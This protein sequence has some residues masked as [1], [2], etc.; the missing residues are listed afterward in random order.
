MSR[1]RVRPVVLL[2]VTLSTLWPGAEGAAPRAHDAGWPRQLERLEERLARLSSDID[3]VVFLRDFTARLMDVGRP[4]AATLSRYRAVDFS[5]FDDA[6]YYPQFRDDQL[7]AACGITTF[8]YLKL[9]QRFGF[10]AYQYSFGFTDPPFARFIHSVTLVEVEHDGQRRLVVQDPYLNLT[11]RT[12]AGAP[13]DFDE[14]LRALQARR[15]DDIVMD[16]APVITSLL[17]PDLAVY[18]AQLS[19]Q[20]R[21]LMR[22]VLTRAD[23]TRRTS[24]P[25]VRSYATLMQ[26]PCDA[27]EAGFVAALRQHGFDE[28]LLFAYTLRAAP[29]VGSAGASAVQQHIDDLLGRRA[30][31]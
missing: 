20:C 25:I 21:S 23:G 4:D 3:K 19:P 24:L 7:P 29:V 6:A 11:Y 2:L 8:F 14:F 26:S 13:M 17:V 22:T 1:G 9:L 30:D 18:D 31:P 28:P 12:R 15:Y 27:F 10:R 16:A 5:T